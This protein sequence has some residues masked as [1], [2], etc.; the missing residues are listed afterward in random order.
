MK[1]L[2]EVGDK[3]KYIVLA[4]ITFNIGLGPDAVLRSRR[5][6]DGSGNISSELRIGIVRI[7]CV[8]LTRL[9]S[10]FR[11]GSEGNYRCVTTRMEAK[12]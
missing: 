9:A 5:Y 7:T 4:L 8:L 3:G 6:P 11:Y 10:T 2:V 12:V 1:I